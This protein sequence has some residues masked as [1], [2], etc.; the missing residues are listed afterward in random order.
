MPFDHAQC[1]NCEAILDPERL[2][3]G[4]RG[5][6]CP[7]CD[8]PLRMVDLFGVVDA[9]TDE[10][11]P[12]LTLDDLVPGSSP[13]PLGGKRPDPLTLDALVPSKKR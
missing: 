3:R 11:Q 6:H 4:E 9:F 10:E 1:P 7:N 2:K 8:T 12:D 13:S 5:P